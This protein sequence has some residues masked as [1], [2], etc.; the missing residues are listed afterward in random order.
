MSRIEFRTNSTAVLRDTDAERS[1]VACAMLDPRL[2]DEILLTVRAEMIFESA[3][4][5]V[6]ATCLELHLA[7]KFIDPVSIQREL[8]KKKLLDE[9]GGVQF[10]MTLMETVPHTAHWSY[11]ADAVKIDWMRRQALQAGERI[12]RAMSDPACDPE[13]AI[14]SADRSMVEL[15]ESLDSG[16]QD[17]SDVK[18][19]LFN[20]EDAWQ[21]GDE[22]TKGIPAHTANLTEIVGGFGAGNMIIVA[23]RPSVGK[24]AFALNLMAHWSGQ[25]LSGLMISAEQSK[26]EIAER[27]LAIEVGA[28]LRDMREGRVDDLRLNAAKSDMSEWKLIIDDRGGPS[29][30][31]VESMARLF[32]RKVDIHFLVVDY[33]QLIT[34]ADRKVPREQQVAENSSRL[35]ALAKSLGIPV[36]VLAQLNRQLESRDTKRPRMS[37]LRESGSIEQDADK[38]ILLW[39]QF[40]DSVEVTADQ[41]REAVA[42]VAKNRQG[43]VGD[44]N[45]V[46]L[47]ESFRFV[48]RAVNNIPASAWE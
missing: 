30:T 35:K 42:I 36:I 38:V 10:I 43:P 14:A 21:K 37:D 29:I 5:E 24:T 19:I 47:A 25:G 8:K 31:Q 40:M 3:S 4:R 7:N 39:R 45:M 9:V 11:Y 28:S 46:Y 44:A 32:K 23:A 27:L 41:K 34:P 20:L 33:L 48:E 12:V 13:A 1:L 26:L 18:S 22:A 17:A 16:S 6:F 2:I 15:I